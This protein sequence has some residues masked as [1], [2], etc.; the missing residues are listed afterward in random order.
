MLEINNISKSFG[1]K[2]VLSGFSLTVNQYDKIGILGP[3][4]C[5]KSTLLNIVSGLTS[6]SEGSLMLDG[7]VP[8]SSEYRR[9]VGM[10]LDVPLYTEELTINEMFVFHSKLYRMPRELFNA[11][12]EFC[13]E[14]CELND[15]LNTTIH[16]LSK[17]YR[18]RMAF[19]LSIFHNPDY[20]L[21]DEPFNG[22][23]EEIKN[24]LVE[25]LKNSSHTI[26][27]SIHEKEVIA[28]ICNRVIEYD[29]FTF[30]ENTTLLCHFPMA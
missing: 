29:N 24:K 26:L 13:S 15:Y 23:E 5:G 2:E 18:A 22:M 21:L 19:A 11:R 27:L 8:S 6:T 4:G 14:L 3:N 1:D 30:A 7:D 20:L 28:G 17:G 12:K 9:K 16:K 25:F 10:V